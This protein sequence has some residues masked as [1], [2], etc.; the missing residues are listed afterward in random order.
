MILPKALLKFPFEIYLYKD[1][2]NLRASITSENKSQ[3]HI[4]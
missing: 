2:D 4:G 1:K 3:F